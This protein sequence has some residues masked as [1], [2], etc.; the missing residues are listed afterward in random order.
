MDVKSSN[1]GFTL[2]ELGIVIIILAIITT[3]AVP[4]FVDLLSR[5][6][7][8]SLQSVVGTLNASSAS[9]FGLRKANPSAGVGVDN[10]TDVESAIPGGALP[11]GFSIISQ[12]VVDGEEVTCSVINTDTDEQGAFVGFGVS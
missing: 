11:E 4:R 8:A 6:E 2:I 10:C 7:T 3:V 12:A 5:S 1:A 9:N